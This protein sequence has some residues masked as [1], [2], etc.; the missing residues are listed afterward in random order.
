MRITLTTV[1]FLFLLSCSSS[2]NNKDDPLK[3]S[4][5]LITEGHSSLYNNGA[6][7]VPGTSIKLI[8][9]GPSTLEF[10][11][12]LAGLR[13]RQSFQ[14]SVQHA[15]EAMALAPK[16]VRKSISISQG[17]RKSTEEI[18]ADANRFAASGITLATNSPK[19]TYRIIKGSLVLS[20]QAGLATLE[21]GDDVTKAS[22]SSAGE[23][24]SASAD[25]SKSLLQNSIHSSGKHL[26]QSFESGGASFSKAGNRFVQGY[27]ALPETLSK[28]GHE[29]AQA[30]SFD[31]FKSRFEDS[32]EW[33]EGASGH[34][35]DITVDA[36]SNYSARVADSFSKAKHE[37]TVNKQDIG[38]TLASLKALRWV[39]QGIFWDGIVEPTAKITYGTIGYLATNTLVF[40]VLLVGG[41]T[42]AAAEVAV[43]VTW[44]SAAGLYELVAP[45]AEAAIAGVLGIGKIVGGTTIAAGEFTLGSTAAGA[46]YIGG[47]TAAGATAVAGVAAGQTIKYVGAP[48]ATVGVASVGSL[49]GVVVGT[50]SAV[51][52]T[53]MAISGYTAGAATATTGAVASTGV[54]LGGSA[55]SAVAATGL[56]GYELSKAVIVPTAYEVGAGIVLGYDSIAQ[57]SAHSVL[58][59]SDVAYVVLSLEGPRWV[60]YGIKGKTHSGDDLIPGTMVNL[61]AM[62]DEGEEIYRL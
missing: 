50:G 18:V 58:A 51:A 54:T 1:F 47:Q 35:T 9:A 8:P 53:G 7:E 48:I 32:N 62:Q 40:P 17:I 11:S 24:S 59:A 3:N 27:V 4:K 49:T 55:V 33:R 45:T 44:N 34:F 38:I 30:A 16:G 19:W 31:K 12:E 6:F 57:L 39:L 13:A 52:G 22:L 37:I 15:K 2:G 21:A 5:Q 43:G 60:V 61:K 23:I 56:A 29:M 46:T 42:I 28:R 26:S 14:L 36:T 10:A 41:Q 20:G 25:V